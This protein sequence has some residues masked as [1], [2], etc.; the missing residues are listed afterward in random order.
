[1]PGRRWGVVVQPYQGMPPKPGAGTAVVAAVLALITGLW[2]FAGIPW[3]GF[4]PIPEVIAGQFADALLGLL[5][6]LGGV[7]LLARKGAGR[8]LSIVGAALA[9]LGL[10]ASTVLAEL[11]FYFYAG[12]PAPFDVGSVL[13]RRALLMLPFVLLLVFAA[14]P[15]TGRWTRRQR[16]PMITYGHQPYPQQPYPPHQQGGRPP[17]W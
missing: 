13:L 8:V 9:L 16:P 17:G 15:A 6:V 4:Y 12:G 7:L 5:L 10:V 3:I 1:M 14:L 2:F 11:H